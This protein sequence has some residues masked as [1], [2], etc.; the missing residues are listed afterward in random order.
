MTRA[1]RLAEDARHGGP[2]LG[3]HRPVVRPQSLEELAAHAVDL[4]QVRRVELAHPGDRLGDRLGPELITGTPLHGVDRPQRVVQPQ[5]VEVLQLGQRPD[6]PA[7]VRRVLGVTFLYVQPSAVQR[8]VDG[9]AA[10]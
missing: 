3:D 9:A 10:Q 8:E 7:L 1:A 4:A 6:E 5:Q 2:V